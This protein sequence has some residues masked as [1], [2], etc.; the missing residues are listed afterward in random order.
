ML[1]KT[2][3]FL[4]IRAAISLFTRDTPDSCSESGSVGMMSGGVACR[5][6]FRDRIEAISLC[7]QEISLEMRSRT[8]LSSVLPLL[9][10]FRNR[11][12]PMAILAHL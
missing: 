5:L 11:N 8:Y 7:Q 2:G 6:T 9:K 3:S 4:A 12:F 10:K 1:F